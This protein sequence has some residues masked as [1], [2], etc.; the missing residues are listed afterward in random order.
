MHHF[1]TSVAEEN[2]VRGRE[3]FKPEAGF[4]PV[5]PSVSCDVSTITIFTFLLLGASLRTFDAIG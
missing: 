2:E 4:K 5:L 1:V 3:F